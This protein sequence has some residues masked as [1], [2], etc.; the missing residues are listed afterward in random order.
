M[1]VFFNDFI[2][3]I[4]NKNYKKLNVYSLPNVKTAKMCSYIVIQYQIFYLSGLQVSS[5][6]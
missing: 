2:F 6:S 5:K 1:Y 3:K 4:S